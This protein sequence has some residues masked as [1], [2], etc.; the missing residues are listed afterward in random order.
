MIIGGIILTIIMFLLLIGL[1]ILGDS[2][3]LPLFIFH[4]VVFLCLSIAGF[5][6]GIIAAK[7]EPS[8]VTGGVGTGVYG[9]FILYTLWFI[10]KIIIPLLPIATPGVK[11][12]WLIT[13][14]IMILCNTLG[15]IGG[16]KQLLAGTSGGA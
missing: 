12:I 5:V 11:L 7:K 4:V 16:I 14:L 15:L 13:L 9:F 3:F 2:A 10:F 1:V 8:V 6:V